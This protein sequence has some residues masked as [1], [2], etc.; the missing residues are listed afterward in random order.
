MREAVEDSSGKVIRHML[1][2]LRDKLSPE[3]LN[4]I[5]QVLEEEYGQ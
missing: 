3:S 2:S 5:L 1:F 4:K